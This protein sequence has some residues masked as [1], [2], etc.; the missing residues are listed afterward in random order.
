M[1]PPEHPR[2]ASLMQRERLV[3]GFED[4]MTVLQGLIAH[5]RGEAFDYLIGERTIPE[6]LSAIKA[7]AA[8]LVLA[9]KPVISVNGNTA[10]LCPEELV[11]LSEALNAPLEVNLFY[12]S[13]ERAR[14]IAEHL[15]RHGAER[16]L[17]RCDAEIE[18]LSSERRRV[19]SS[20]IYASDVVL[21]AIEDGDRTLALKR[22]GKR[23]VAIDLNPLSRT[24]QEADITVVDEVTRAL[25]LLTA[26][27]QC[28]QGMSAEELASVL[29][30]F[31][32][33]RNLGRVLE[34]M[35]RRLGE[36]SGQSL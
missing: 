9:S 10:V 21:L 12:R 26:Q 5:G 36:L 1:I 32:N 27:V 17:W 20:G 7:G 34:H 13:E 35:R 24:A 8:A 22:L 11:R 28:M 19:S 4:G 31:D 2:Y 33:R 25:P 18:G 14:R 30:G 23:V 16:V 15:R 3:R 6:A 29:E